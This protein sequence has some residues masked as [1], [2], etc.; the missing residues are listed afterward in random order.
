[1]N[2]RPGL[3]TVT[4]GQTVVVRSPLGRNV[5]WVR[6]TV[7]KVGRVWIDVEPL[8]GEPSLAHY[9]VRF[10]MDSQASGVRSSHWFVTED[11][12]VWD[13]E[14]STA[15]NVLRDARIDTSPGFRDGLWSSG[16]RLL[17][18]AAFVEKYDADHPEGSA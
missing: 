15:K 4:V 18:M 3:G 7:T 8:E 17:A 5:R 1:M 16:D 11:Q 13:L 12:Y 10:R 2:K 14:Q 9:E 6:C